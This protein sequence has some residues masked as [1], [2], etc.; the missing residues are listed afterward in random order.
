MSPLFPLLGLLARG[1]AYGYELKRIVESE[2]APQWR[3]DFA[4]LYRSLAKLHTGG[5]VRVRTATGEGGPSRRVY[6]LTAQGRRALTRWLQDRDTPSDEFW[7]KA[8]FAEELELDMPL[9]LVIAGSDDPL[10]AQLAQTLYAHVQVN[11][12]TAGLFALASQ[13]ADVVGTHLR[14]PDADEYNVSFVQH[15]IPE[16][17]VLLV[18][19]AVREYGL[20]VAQGNPHKI[21]SVR[22]I[23]RRNLRLVN[24]PR[25][26]GA[27]L[28]LQRHVTDAH[29]DPAQL[30]GWTRTAETYQAVAR[31][32]AEDTADTGPGLRAT[33]QA[34][35]LDFVPVGAER[36][37]LALSRTLY[38]SAR[39]QL[40]REALHSK[41]FRTFARALPGYDF[42]SSGRVMAE[43]KYG[44]RRKP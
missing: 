36:F 35:D 15:L 9:P 31:A 11:G 14:D 38:E 44:L 10:L 24:R 32:I 3:I 26:S 23:A 22:D 12:S 33:A 18:N 43:I 41:T 2:F 19:L 42:S 30:K 25:G 20:L 13:N 5:L 8:R 28:W 4:Q 34:L 7:L 40:F 16:Q 17:D 6:A 27:R 21:G 29:L 1:E 37:D 39:G